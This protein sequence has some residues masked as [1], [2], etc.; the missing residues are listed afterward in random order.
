MSALLVDGTIIENVTVLDGG[1][2]SPT[3]II[4]LVPNME[5]PSQDGVTITQ[6]SSYTTTGRQGWNAFVG[7]ADFGDE[8]TVWVSATHTSGEYVE[9]SFDDEVNI[10]MFKISTNETYIFRF[11]YYDESTSSWLDANGD[12][13]STKV[14]KTEVFT[15]QKVCKAKKFRF[16]MVDAN[17]SNSHPFFAFG[18]A[19][20][21]GTKK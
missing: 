11:E 8:N 3:S 21:Y 5:S 1:G 13:A 12:M 15:L 20:L 14:Q 9:I 10:Y 19:Q 6:S 18:D 7:Y 16:T 2:S 4:P 17:G